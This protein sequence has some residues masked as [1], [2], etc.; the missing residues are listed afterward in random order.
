MMVEQ[1]FFSPQVKRSAVICN[2]LVYTCFLITCRKTKDL[3]NQ[4]LENQPLTITTKCSIPDAAVTPDPSLDPQ[5]RISCPVPPLRETAFILVKND[6]MLKKQPHNKTNIYIL[7]CFTKPI[8]RYI[9][10]GIYLLKFNNSKTRER[11]EICSKLTIATPER[12]LQRCSGAFIVNSKHISNLVLSVAVVTLE[13]I[14]A[15]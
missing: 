4:I 11:C 10:V 6:F 3:A 14:N 7:F 12:L 13:Q 9:P 2:Q 15:G 8:I 1:I 5:F